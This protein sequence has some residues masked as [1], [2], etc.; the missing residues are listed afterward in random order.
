MYAIIEDSGTQIKVSEGDVIDVD[1]RA[2]GDDQADLTFD[3]VLVIGGG[4]G[5]ATLG[6]PLIEG[7]TVKADILDEG[8]GPKIEIIK[9]KRRKGY[10]RRNGHRQGRLRVRVTAISG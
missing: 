4:E 5:A 9:F 7:A 1:L 2:L 10:T 3:R 6:S 8:R